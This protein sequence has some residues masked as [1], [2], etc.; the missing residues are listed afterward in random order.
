MLLNWQLFWNS[1]L[2]TDFHFSFS[3]IFQAF[4]FLILSLKFSL[5]PFRLKSP[6]NTSGQFSVTIIVTLTFIEVFLYAQPLPYIM[7]IGNATMDKNI[8]FLLLPMTLWEGYCGCHCLP[9]GNCRKKR[10]NNL[11]YIKPRSS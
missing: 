9:R 6:M 10:L 2:Y 1:W 4:P 3:F 7:V 8:F 5:Y 11:L